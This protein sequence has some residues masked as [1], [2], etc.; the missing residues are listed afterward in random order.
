MA[1]FVVRRALKYPNHRSRVR[2][3]SLSL[4]RPSSWIYFSLPDVRPTNPPQCPLDACVN[5]AG[6]VQRDFNRSRRDAL[7][8]G[9]VI[10]RQ[11][12]LQDSR[13]PT[14]SVFH[15]GLS[16]IMRMD[17]PAS[18]LAAHASLTTAA[19]VLGVSHHPRLRVRRGG[20]GTSFA[21]ASRILS[22]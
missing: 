4:V 17:R 14:T 7:Q 21:I 16:L 3:L 8:S 15:A 9:H 1:R 19:A 11:T 10:L 20:G 12:P 13:T 18:S 6:S 5:P 2:T 22:A